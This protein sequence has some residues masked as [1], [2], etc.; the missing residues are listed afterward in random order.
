MLPDIYLN[1]GG[2]T[3]SYFEWIKN[4][5]H[6]RFGRLQR[7]RDEMRGAQIIDL[8]EKAM[9]KEVPA[10]IAARF[11]H[12]ADEHDLVLSGLDDTMRGAYQQMREVLLSRN[13]VEDLR[14]AAFVVAIEKIVLCYEEMG[15]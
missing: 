9:G 7:R 2:V 10:E 12:S 15:I 3:V 6:I 8:I 4:L 14:T 1:A 5:S 13:E 11:T